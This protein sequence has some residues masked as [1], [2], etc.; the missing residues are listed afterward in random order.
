MS[1]AAAIVG[2]IVLWMCLSMAVIFFN[3]SLL[4]KFRHP[5]ALVCWHQVVSCMLVAVIQVVKPGMLETGDDA[6]GIPALTLR[7]SVKLGMPVA[8]MASLGLVTSNTAYLYLTVSFIQ[9]IKAWTSSC[10]YVVGCMTGTQ[11]WS[12]PIAK[13]LSI[14]TLGLMISSAGELNFNA[15]GFCMQVVALLAEAV[16]INMLEIRLKS[17]GYKLNPISSMK[18]FAPLIMIL[19]VVTLV[20]VDPGAIDVDQIAEIGWGSFALNGMVACGLNLA[21]FLVIKTSSGLLYALSGVLKDI[22]IISGSAIFRG[23]SIT[24]LQMAGYALAVLGLQVYAAVSRGPAEFEAGIVP[25]LW[26]RLTQSVKQS[27]A[28][29]TGDGMSKKDKQGAQ[30]EELRGIIGAVTDVEEGE[31]EEGAKQVVWNT[32]SDDL[33]QDTDT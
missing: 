18:I 31:E 11:T 22:L 1:N 28:A 21:V 8:L 6:N 16:R 27:S 29:K 30:D 14:V 10:V 25:E 20:L 17:A 7:R 3:A 32:G 33:V 2:T 9:M 13:T 26:R 12:W 24:P 23:D 5:I 15:Y 4:H 19:L